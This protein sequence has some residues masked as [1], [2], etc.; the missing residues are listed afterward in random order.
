MCT[1]RVKEGKDG[2]IREVV[3][4]CMMIE[5]SRKD[6]ICVNVVENY[7]YACSEYLTSKT[8]ILSCSCDVRRE[9]GVLVSSRSIH[10]RKVMEDEDMFKDLRATLEKRNSRNESIHEENK[11]FGE[12]VT[13]SGGSIS[14]GEESEDKS[15]CT[16]VDRV[17]VR[18]LTRRGIQIER[19]W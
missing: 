5:R 10:I 18:T 13:V 9:D 14:V 17:D 15:I 12:W 7:T 19:R 2:G 11:S 6:V 3:T 1:V 8:E 16:Q 4:I